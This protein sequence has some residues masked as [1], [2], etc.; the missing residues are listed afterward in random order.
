MKL[1]CTAQQRDDKFMIDSRPYF[2]HNGPLSRFLPSSVVNAV[3]SGDVFDYSH[4]HI[5][6][7]EGTISARLDTDVT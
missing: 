7:G 4:G 3:G 2:T 1:S 6:G 5:G